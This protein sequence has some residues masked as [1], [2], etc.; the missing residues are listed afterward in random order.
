MNIPI[1]TAINNLIWGGI[2]EKN[3][4]FE[5]INL[6]NQG[7]IGGIVLFKRNGEDPY[8][9]QK[10]I[11]EIK[12]SYSKDLPLPAISID[13]EGGRVQRIKGD[14]T[15][16]PP[17]KK[18]G[19]IN[20]CNTAFKLGNLVGKELNCLG[21]DVNFSPVLDIIKSNENKVIGDRSLGSDP[22]LAGNIAVSFAKGME[23][24]GVM[25]CGKHFP[26]HGCTTVDS[27]EKL[28][29]AEGNINK[30]E[31]S[32]L[33]PFVNY[34][35]NNFDLLMTAHIL[36][37]DWDNQNPATYSN[38][39]LNKLLRKKLGFKGIVIT[40]D[41]E[42]G[43]I[44]NEIS[45][46]QAAYKSILAGA[47]VLLICGFNHELRIRIKEYLLKQAQ[48]NNELESRIYESAQ[49]NLNFRKKLS[50][51][52]KYSIDFLKSEERKKILQ[53]LSNIF[54]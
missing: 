20:D 46:E 24:S 18:L 32:D 4:T 17:F 10:L 3:L 22:V 47:D 48:K 29:I 25:A 44:Q 50:A 51:I 35:N 27:H 42:M 16:L 2:K 43:A 53:D 26:G 15:I 30:W 9:I 28:P 49:K 6:L 54:S 40:D 38:Y 37:K 11:S 13:H 41:L 39:I 52:P 19:D 1:I 8:Q 23:I 14:L 5:E 36:Y 34:I 7:Q 45:I 31:N 33:K 12:Q 21:I